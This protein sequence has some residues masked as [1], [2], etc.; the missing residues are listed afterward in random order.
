MQPRKL[1]RLTP[2]KAHHL[3]SDGAFVADLGVVVDDVTV[4][5]PLYR[6]VMI[7]EL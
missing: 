6:M 1:I 5:C 4:S 3:R 7:V 2:A